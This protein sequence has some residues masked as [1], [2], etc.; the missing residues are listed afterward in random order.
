MYCSAEFYTESTFCTVFC[1]ISLTVH[2]DGISD[3]RYYRRTLISV[4]Q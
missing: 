3:R 4:T 1:C 2:N